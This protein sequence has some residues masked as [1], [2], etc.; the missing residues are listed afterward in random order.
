MLYSIY[1]LLYSIDDVLYVYSISY[2]ISYKL[3]SDASEVFRLQQH[4]GG[5]AGRQGEGAATAEHRPALSPAV[6]GSYNS[7]TSYY[8]YYSYYNY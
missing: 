5:G 8:S 4:G 2:M 1:Y 7:Y 6:G 3:R